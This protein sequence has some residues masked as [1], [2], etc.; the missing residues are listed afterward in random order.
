M[1]VGYGAFA[2]GLDDL[3]A[4]ATMLEGGA[5]DLSSGL[6]LVDQAMSLLP[7]QVNE[8]TLALSA[9][10]EG[11]DGAL[12]S[13]TVLFLEQNDRSSFVSSQNPNPLSTQFIITLKF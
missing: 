6:S 13:I 1:S 4:A 5:S 9:I 10:S 3:V 12:D 11:F 2:D 8:L 7:D